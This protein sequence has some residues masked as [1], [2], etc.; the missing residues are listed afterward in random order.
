MS[1]S[2]FRKGSQ[3]AVESRPG[4]RRGRGRGWPRHQCPRPAGR[5]RQRGF[6]R[7]PVDLDGAEA[8]ARRLHGRRE[9]LSV[10]SR[11]LPQTTRARA[12]IGSH[13]DQGLFGCRAGAGG[14]HGLS[15]GVRPGAGAG[16]PA[17]HDP[18][19]I[20]S[21]RCGRLGATE[22]IRRGVGSAIPR[23]SV[24]VR[25]AGLHSSRRQTVNEDDPGSGAQRQRETET[26]QGREA[27]PVGRRTGP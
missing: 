2:P 11:P 8:G 13:R 24:G 4:G 14:V 27:H 23:V 19:V 16:A 21:G 25:G 7:P 1:T 20:G 10:G 3:T 26:G 6:H 9:T 18:R 12:D 22:A 5:A 15:D 17:S